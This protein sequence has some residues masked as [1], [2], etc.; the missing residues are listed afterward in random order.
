MVILGPVSL[1]E[2]LG[3]G[4]GERG[5]FWGRSPSIIELGSEGCLKVLMLL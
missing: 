1:E 2:V 4:A 3:R 5:M